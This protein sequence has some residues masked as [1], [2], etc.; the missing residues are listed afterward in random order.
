MDATTT[1]AGLRAHA[2]L[3]QEQAFRLGDLVT[4]SF[5]PKTRELSQTIQADIAAGVRLLQAVDESRSEGHVS[6]KQQ[7]LDLARR[8]ACGRTG[9]DETRE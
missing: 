1:R 3:T 5:H 9:A 8:L 6:N 7:A 2:F 4:E